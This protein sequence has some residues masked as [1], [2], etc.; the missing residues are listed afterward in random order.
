M[1]CQKLK[2]VRRECDGSVFFRMSQVVVKEKL[3]A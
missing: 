2:F 3:R 1:E